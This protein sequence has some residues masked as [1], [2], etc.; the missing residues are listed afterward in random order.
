MLP[1]R[2]RSSPGARAASRDIACDR[3]LGYALCRIAEAEARTGD[4]SA[5]L[6]SIAEA[7]RLA[8]GNIGASEFNHIRSEIAVA[9]ATAGDNQGAIATSRRI[10]D[11]PSRD[12]LL[13]ELCEV[14]CW[15]DNSREAIATARE[16]ASP[17]VRSDALA[18]IARYRVRDG[19]ILGAALPIAAAMAAAGAIVDRS[20]RA[21]ALVELA[22]IQLE[23]VER[24]GPQ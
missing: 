5:A 19:D 9:Q 6:R 22:E 21:Q 3:E 23:A 12:A 14:Q 7:S 16:I 11:R 18:D 13:A 2:Q 17:A 15:E 4:R 1:T 24:R 10:A 20:G 8:N